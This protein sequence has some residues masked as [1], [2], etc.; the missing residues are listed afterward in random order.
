MKSAIIKK[1]ERFGFFSERYKFE[2]MSDASKDLLPCVSVHMWK[3]S[4]WP[5]LLYCILIGQNG[6]ITADEGCS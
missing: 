3:E 1:S 2:K 5:F 6:P 4:V